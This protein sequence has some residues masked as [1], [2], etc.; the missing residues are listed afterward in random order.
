[1]STLTHDAV[2]PVPISVSLDS[3][4][5]YKLPD[6]ELIELCLNKDEEAWRVLLERH[7]GLIYSIAWAEAPPEDVPD[8][9]QSVCLALVQGLQRLHDPSKLVAWIATTTR[10]HCQRLRQR[11]RRYWSAPDEA[12]Q[13]AN[14]PVDTA[15]L[16]DEK[17]QQLQ[18]AHLV[19]QAVTM[20]DEPCRGLLTRLFYE[21]EPPSY[22][23][24]AGALNWPVSSV[25]P[26]RGRCL[27]R[28]R[29]TLEQ[30]GFSPS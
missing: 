2:G 13:R 4:L 27:Q 25:G 17:L 23:A 16:P 22:E 1:M 30:I 7:G 12:E 20:L 19:H 18:Q 9:F 6:A 3:R 11:R 15:A 8:I 5:H 29:R 28:L 14:D 26:K 21:D 24:I 10:R